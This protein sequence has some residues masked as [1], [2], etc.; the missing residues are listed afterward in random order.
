MEGPKP[1]K[2]KSKI[3][4]NP[5]RRSEVESLID[6]SNKLFNKFWVKTMSASD[7]SSW[8]YQLRIRFGCT[9]T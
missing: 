3:A 6:E 4:R 5:V 9:S 1:E 7:W 2:L 8:I